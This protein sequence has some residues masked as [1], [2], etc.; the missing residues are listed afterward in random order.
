MSRTQNAKARRAEMERKLREIKARE[1]TI[2][3]RI[4]RLEAS[5]TASPGMESARRI[6]LWNTLPAEADE[7]QLRPH[8]RQTRVQRELENNARSQ[9]ALLALALLGVAA[10]VS[11]FLY[12]LARTHGLISL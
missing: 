2:K 10:A 11:Y 1:S 4:Y 5:I 6:S 7:S 9:Q 3:E 8:R 12:T